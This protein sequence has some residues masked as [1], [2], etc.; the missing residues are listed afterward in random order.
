MQYLKK[1]GFALINTIIIISLLITL[2]SFMFSLIKNNM[3]I[4]AMNCI[5][6]DIFS[7]DE[8]EEKII[9]EFMEVLNNKNEDSRMN[10]DDK[11]NLH[12]NFYDEYEDRNNIYE[13]VM[14]FNVGDESTITNIFCKDFEEENRGNKLIYKKDEDKLILNVY[15]KYNFLRIRELKYIVK[16]NEIILLPTENFIDTNNAI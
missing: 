2:S 4:S 10:V 14:D 15:G 6:K 9:Y 5:D 11:N 12:G 13:E 8:K 16:N 7:I 3:Y 1:D